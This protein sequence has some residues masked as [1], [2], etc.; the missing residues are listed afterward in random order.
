MRVSQKLIASGSLIT[1][2]KHL[3][4]QKKQRK[5]QT[6]I[7]TPLVLTWIACLVYAILKPYDLKGIELTI[8]WVSAL[9]SLIITLVIIL[10]LN[11]K[12][13]ETTDEMVSD[14][15]QSA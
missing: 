6:I 13:D 14:I 11:R 10:W 7:M 8:V 9:L 5:I 15:D 12:I 2:K 3:L 4:K 1:I